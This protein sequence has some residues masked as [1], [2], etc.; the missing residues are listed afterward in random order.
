MLKFNITPLD[1]LLFRSGRPFN[2]GDYAESIFPPSP[3]TFAGA[4]GGKLWTY[5]CVSIIEQN[6]ITKFYGPF[7]QKANIFYFP[8]PLNILRERKTE[9]SEKIY[10]SVSTKDS[11]L[12]NSKNMNIEISQ[13]PWVKTDKEVESFKG[14]ISLEGL[15]YWLLGDYNK[16]TNEHLLAYKDIFETESRIGI[17][18]KFT[19]HTTTEEDG[20]YRVNFLRV[21]DDINFVCWIDFKDKDLKEIFNRGPKI[22]QLGGERRQVVYEM[23]ESDFEGLFRDLKNKITI[24]KGSLIKVL[25]LTPAVFNNGW[26]PEENN[27][28]ELEFKSCSIGKYIN[29]GKWDSSKKDSKTGKGTLRRAIPA[30]SIYWYEAKKDFD[31]E[32]LWLTHKTKFDE[33]IGS[34]L[35]IVGIEK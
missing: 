21:K 25:Y 20:L 33:F 8:I 12:I 10:I 32:R 28:E 11:K 27:L 1:V 26:I 16:I 31:I 5:K 19:T 23:E 2:P 18:T 9:E 30:G 35:K 24:K 34:N 13:L 29:I 15:K 14:F 7:I 3:H 17:R 6:I 22:F 4:I